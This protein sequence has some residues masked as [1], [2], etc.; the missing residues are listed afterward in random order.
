MLQGSVAPNKPLTNGGVLTW[1]I[2]YLANLGRFVCTSQ[3]VTHS[4]LNPFEPVLTM[5][6]RESHSY[7][8]LGDR[9]TLN[10][11]LKN[12][13]CFLKETTI[14][15]REFINNILF[16]RHILKGTYGCIYIYGSL[17][18]AGTQV[19]LDIGP[20]GLCYIILEVR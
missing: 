15:Y 4:I 20:I 16:H 17:E 11:V 12:A 8:I 14:S 2:S 6:T 3:I 9:C 5:S 10:L 13:F 1:R 18:K 19:F 7:W